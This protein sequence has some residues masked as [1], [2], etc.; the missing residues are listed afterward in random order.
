MTYIDALILGILEGATE[1]LP[2]SS[3]GHLILASKILSIPHSDAQTSFIIA[4]QCGAIL[5]VAL[6]YRKQIFNLEL[7][8]KLFVAFIPTAVVGF[9]LYP[10][11]KGFLLSSE[12]TVVIA[13][14]VGGVALIL[15]DRWHKEP[16]EPE[17]GVVRDI[18]YKQA[19]FVGLFQALAVVPGVSRSAASIIGGL[20]F[21]MRRTTAVEFSFL[22]ALPTLGAA[23]AYDLL[24]S[25][26]S[27]AAADVRVLL[28]GFIAAFLSAFV[29]LRFFRSFIKRYSFTSFGVYRIILALIFFTFF[30]P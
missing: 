5:S 28:L 26:E 21:G 13:L 11:I 3:T 18:S 15:F 7:L 27:F 6:L 25:H 9:T 12:H 23:T 29:A 4:I 17:E 8:K 20:M 30:L 2:V 14:F 22:L 1:F 10:L 19:F 16:P 24:K